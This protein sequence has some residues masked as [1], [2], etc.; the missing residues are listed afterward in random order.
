MKEKKFKAWA[1]ITKRGV[2]IDCSDNWGVS[3]TIFTTRKAGQK[4]L[5]DMEMEKEWKV[6]PC[7]IVILK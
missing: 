1:I 5:K 6:V 2:I 4:Y 3:L 7:E